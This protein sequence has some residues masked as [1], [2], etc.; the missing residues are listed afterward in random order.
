MDLVLSY[1]NRDPYRLDQLM[2]NLTELTT[3]T[4]AGV[5]S[6]DLEGRFWEL[7]ENE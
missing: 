1:V 5:L 3:A 7:L 6:F 2:S 4:A